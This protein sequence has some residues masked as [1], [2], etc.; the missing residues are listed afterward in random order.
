MRSDEGV[1][2]VLLGGGGGAEDGG[3]AGGPPAPHPPAALG[4]QVVCGGERV[5]E[6]E[7][8]KEL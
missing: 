4:H 2:I 1:G 5:V 3:G 8:H 6:N 7:T